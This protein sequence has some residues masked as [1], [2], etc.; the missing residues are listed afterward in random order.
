MLRPCIWLVTVLVAVPCGALAQPRPRNAPGIVK[1]VNAESLTI[2]TPNGERTFTLTPRTEYVR[3]EPELSPGSF[4][5]LRVGLRVLVNGQADKGTARRV[6]IL[7]R[8][9]H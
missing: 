1:S 7:L 8:A 2:T 6:L 9:T 4:S 5:D 3:A